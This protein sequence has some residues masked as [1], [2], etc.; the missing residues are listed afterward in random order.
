MAC[1]P[2]NIDSSSG[3]DMIAFRVAVSKM[4]SLAIWPVRPQ[5]DGT[6]AVT[7]DSGYTWNDKIDPNPQYQTDQTKSRLAEIIT[8]GQA[9]PYQI[10]VTWHAQSTVIL[11]SQGNVLGV[12]GYPAP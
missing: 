7:L 8:L 5:P 4:S 3:A 10:H 9:D 2:L 6:Y 11:D 12:Q 1:G